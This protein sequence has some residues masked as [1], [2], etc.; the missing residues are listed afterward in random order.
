MLYACVY[1]S[2][3][4]GYICLRMYAVCKQCRHAGHVL[5]M[6]SVLCNVPSC[7]HQANALTCVRVI[8]HQSLVLCTLSWWRGTLTLYMNAIACACNANQCLKWMDEWMNGWMNEPWAMYN[9]PWA[10]SHELCTMSNEPCTMSHEPCTMS[11]EPWAMSH[12]QWAMSNEPWAM[13]AMSS[14]PWAMSH[15]PRAMYN[16][17]W[18]MSSEPWAMSHVQWA[19]YHE[20]WPMSNEQ[21]AMRN[22]QLSDEHGN[23]QALPPCPE[24]RL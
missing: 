15:E 5:C 19:M 2:C 11:H 21:W 20:Q 14:E 10:M 6:D 13:W 3:A 12:V 8:V 24:V 1:C 7:I 22:A 9:E 18:A 17:P 23:R 4:Y 16:E